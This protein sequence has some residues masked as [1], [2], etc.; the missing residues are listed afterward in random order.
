M[1]P[2]RPGWGH[3]DWRYT[4]YREQLGRYFELMNFFGLQFL[5]TVMVFWGTVPLFW[6]LSGD[7]PSLIAVLP[8]AGQRPV[9][10]R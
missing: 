10:R 7:A 2:A 5:P 8:G 6:V 3:E 9:E 4:A 1:S